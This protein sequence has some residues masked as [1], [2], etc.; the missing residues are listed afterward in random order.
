MQLKKYI[1]LLSVSLLFACS[2]RDSGADKSSGAVDTL[3][4]VAL[5]TITA[6]SF[7]DSKLTPVFAGYID[8]K[9]KL[10]ETKFEEAQPAAKELAALLQTKDGCENAA[11]IAQRIANA[12]DI[13]TQRAEFTALNT[14]LIPLFKQAALSSGAIYVQHCPMANNGDGGDWLS[15]AKKIQN[16]YYGDEMMEC[17]R[18]LETIAAK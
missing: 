13:K 14:E 7:D 5:D 16:P 12:K 6:P 9:D 11:L 4:H 3:A 10:V 15:S 17:G 8:L 2:T 18:V 1:S